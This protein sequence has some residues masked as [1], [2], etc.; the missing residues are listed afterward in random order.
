[1]KQLL[2]WTGSAD[3][4]ITSKAVMAMTEKFNTGQEVCL[5]IPS[6]L[7]LCKSKRAPLGQSRRVDLS[8]RLPVCPY[9]RTS[10]DCPCWSGS[11]QQWKN[12]IHIAMRHNVGFSSGLRS[13]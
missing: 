9:E 5:Q 12:T 8:R 2:A 10:L 7:E 3:S 6:A 4:T 11:C 13:Y 1:M